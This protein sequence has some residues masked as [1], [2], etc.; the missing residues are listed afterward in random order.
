MIRTGWS[1]SAGPMATCPIPPRLSSLISLPYTSYAYAYAYTCAVPRRAGSSMSR[2]LAMRRGGACPCATPHLR[3]G[4]TGYSAET[5]TVRTRRLCSR[6]ACTQT[7]WALGVH[8]ETGCTNGCT[9]WVGEGEF[10][11]DFPQR[12]D[13]PLSL[14]TRRGLDL[15]LW[16]MR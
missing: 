10:I 4:C 3:K 5:D 8:V 14:G 6:Y 2:C 16:M 12:I 13:S 7:G 15:N 9:K 11:M 1:M